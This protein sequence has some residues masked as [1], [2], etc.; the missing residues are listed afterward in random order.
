M[1]RF[2][3]VALLALAVSVA[4][5]MRAIPR[6]NAALAV[7]RFLLSTACD[8]QSGAPNAWFLI[9]QREGALARIT[10]PGG[11]LVES[12]GSLETRD[13]TRTR[14]KWYVSTALFNTIKVAKLIGVRPQRRVRS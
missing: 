6:A 14:V 1:R 11:L 5:V 8:P 3:G 10:A 4:L 12:I 13:A 2:F 9:P 7:R